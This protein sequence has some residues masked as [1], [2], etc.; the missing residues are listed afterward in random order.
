[1]KLICWHR[2]ELELERIPP[3]ESV[4]DTCLAGLLGVELEVMVSI[5]VHP[6]IWSRCQVQKYIKVVLFLYSPM[7]LILDG[8]S[9]HDAYV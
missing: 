3:L 4:K 9:E 8:S 5:S 6:P 1:M 7:L 2:F